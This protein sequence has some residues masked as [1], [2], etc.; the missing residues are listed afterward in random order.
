MIMADGKQSV[1]DTVLSQSNDVRL[2]TNQIE[3]EE[4]IELD[5]GNLLAVNENKIDTK[6]FKVKNEDILLALTRDATQVLFNSLWKLPVEQKDGAFLITLP[7]S[8]T[9]LPREKH[10]PKKRPPTKWEEYAKTKGILNKK[11]SRMIWDEQSQEYKPRWGYKRAN[12]AT[13]DWL[14]EVPDNADPYEDQYEK[15]KTAKRER[16]AKNEL[17]RLRNVARAQKS[18][19]PGLGL[20]PTEKPSKDHLSKALAVA[21]K[22]TASIGK[23][24]D[25]LPKE[26]PSKFT[27]KKRKFEPSIGNFGSEKEKQLKMLDIVS[28]KV[29]TINTTKA[30][31][32]ILRQDEEQRAQEKKSKKTPKKLK[33]RKATLGLGKPGRQGGGNKKT[34]GKRKR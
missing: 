26:K 17:Q 3:N 21:H 32:R 25:R 1:V 13:K 16:V 20:T 11:K 19:V 7:E 27:G 22:S 4:L 31:N 5:E 33:G 9:W 14:I 8:Q 24:T 34:R 23:F 30:A 15:R 28:K 29:P 10:V 2:E 6:N 12:D 18:K